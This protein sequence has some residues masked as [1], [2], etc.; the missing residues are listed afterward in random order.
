MTE[1][2]GDDD[3]GLIEFE[4]GKYPGREIHLFEAA[5][6]RETEKIYRS[7]AADPRE[8]RSFQEDIYQPSRPENDELVLGTTHAPHRKAEISRV[9]NQIRGRIQSHEG[10]ARTDVGYLLEVIDAYESGR[11]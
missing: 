11:M 10:Q 7:D 9:V 4:D 3:E 1:V 5:A 8:V 2:S 6:Q